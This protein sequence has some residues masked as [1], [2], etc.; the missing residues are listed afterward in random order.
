[1]FEQQKVLIKFLKKK[2]KKINKQILDRLGL[3]SLVIERN[4][5]KS[6]LILGKIQKDIILWAFE[7]RNKNNPKG[8]FIVSPP[9]TGK[10]TAV[11]FS[12]EIMKKPWIWINL[13]EVFDENFVKEVLEEIDY[14]KIVVIDEIREPF[15]SDKKILLFLERLIP[16][17]YATNKTPIFICNPP[18]K[19]EDS[20]R[21]L[22]EKFSVNSISK[23]SEMTKTLKYF[24]NET[25]NFRLLLVFEKKMKKSFPI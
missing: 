7:N 24:N 20:Y 17:L 15:M 22:F 25:F 12:L 13:Y 23:L 3:A 5:T 19:E 6:F 2:Y 8:L 4:K 1:M 14:A 16:K 11:K 21:T 9:G 18:T 10:T